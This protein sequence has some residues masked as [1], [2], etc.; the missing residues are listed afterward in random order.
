MLLE[1]LYEDEHLI[2]VNKPHGLLVH[3]T[4][5]AKEATAFALQLLR[6]QIGQMVYPCHRLDRKTAGVL[7]FAKD[8]AYNK[9]M[10]QLFREQKVKK[11]YK[12]IVR[13]YIEQEGKIDYALKVDDKIQEAIT[14]YKCLEQFE[15]ELPQS[16]GQPFGK[17]KT[18][19]YSLVELRPET[20]R[21]HQL[22]K[23]TAHIF[24][25]I[26]G[27]RPHG[28]NKQ[29]RF[30]KHFYQLDEMMLHAESLSFQLPNGKSIHIKADYS[31]AFYRC[32]HILEG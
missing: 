10:Q 12:A 31:P 23:H 17:Y 16:A 7:L 29:N 13:G 15:L 32:L 21:F 11:A 26:L 5:I 20:G 6:D 3:R 22:R 18:A 2:A 24:H 14:H 1:I 9:I 28:C 25:P 27:D 8:S 4:K 19:R 30:W